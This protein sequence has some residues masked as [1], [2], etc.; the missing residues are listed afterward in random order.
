MLYEVIT[1]EAYPNRVICKVVGYNNA[2]VSE[3]VDKLYYRFQGYS[4]WTE[5]ENGCNG[6]N[7]EISLR[8]NNFV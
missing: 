2:C 6:A 8:R 5:I 4:T 3:H 7:F 1:V